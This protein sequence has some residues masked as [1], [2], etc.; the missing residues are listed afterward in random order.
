MEAIK[1]NQ[2]NFFAWNNLG[3]TLKGKEIVEAGGKYYT[4]QGCCLEAI[5]ANQKNFFAW[6]NLC[7]ALK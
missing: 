6:N 5:K 7:L 4:K 1:A 3:D 2:K